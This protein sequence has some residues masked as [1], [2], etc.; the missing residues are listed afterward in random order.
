MAQEEDALS[1]LPLEL[2]LRVLVWLEPGEI[3]GLARVCR[4]WRVLA[5]TNRV[6]W[7][8]CME[9][10]WEPAHRPTRYGWG[11]V[12]PAAVLA[13]AEWGGQNEPAR[14]QGR[15]AA[16]LRLHRRVAGTQSP[17]A[18]A[19]G[20]VRWVLGVL[21]GSAQALTFLAP[22]PSHPPCLQHQAS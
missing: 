20:H 1:R 9:H 2:L 17:A 10:A 22:A 16:A 18:A 11:P 4:R 21:Q 5:R 13:I 6:W 3:A 8:L 15:L 14:P 19:R 7:R 12:R